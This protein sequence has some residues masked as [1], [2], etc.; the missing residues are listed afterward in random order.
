MDVGIQGVKGGVSLTVVGIDR[1]VISAIAK[2]HAS[3]D[4]ARLPSH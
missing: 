2:Q 1:D 3:M 4:Y